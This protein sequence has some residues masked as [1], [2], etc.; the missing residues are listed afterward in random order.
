MKGSARVVTL[1]L[2]ALS[3]CLQAKTAE[4]SLEDKQTEIRRGLDRYFGKRDISTISD[5]EL[6]D[7]AARP[8][9]KDSLWVFCGVR[10]VLW[11]V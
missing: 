6:I 7:M 4:Q 2:L 8:I 9:G 10:A 5:K 1:L 3:R 11:I